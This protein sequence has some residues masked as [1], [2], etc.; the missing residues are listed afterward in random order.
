MIVTRYDR[1]NIKETGAQ[2]SSLHIPGLGQGF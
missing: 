1:S 2:N